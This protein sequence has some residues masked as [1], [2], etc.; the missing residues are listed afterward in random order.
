MD[1]PTAGSAASIGSAIRFDDL[2]PR[3]ARRPPL[4]GEHT[5]EVLSEWLGLDEAA[6]ENYRRKG[7]FGKDAEH[8]E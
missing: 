7:A 4:L 5:S 2:P 3:G 8:H 1:H 6:T